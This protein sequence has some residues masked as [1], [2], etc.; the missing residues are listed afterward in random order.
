[1][2]DWQKPEAGWKV[3]KSISGNWSKGGMVKFAASGAATKDGGAI[4][5]LEIGLRA[6]NAN[7]FTIVARSRL[8]GKGDELSAR[9]EAA[10]KLPVA[11]YDYVIRWVSNNPMQTNTLTEEPPTEIASAS[12]IKLHLFSNGGP[13]WTAVVPSAGVK[14]DVAGHCSGGLA[15]GWM[16]LVLSTPAK[17]VSFRYPKTGDAGGYASVDGPVPGVFTT[18]GSS[19]LVGSSFG[20]SVR[21]HSASF[22][23]LH[24]WITGIA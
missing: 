22:D 3:G 15:H 16:E 23:E 17:Q 1:V 14:V 19:P 4:V 11:S 5:Q 2:E 12:L 7:D 13:L 18:A 10:L 24:L 9:V 8:T 21:E 20:A 6:P